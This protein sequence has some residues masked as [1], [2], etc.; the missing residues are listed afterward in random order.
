MSTEQPA[1]GSS[2]EDK[3]TAVA[4]H[5]SFGYSS[6]SSGT[7]EFDNVFLGIGVMGTPG[8]LLCSHCRGFRAK[9]P[10]YTSQ[11]TAT[12]FDYPFSPW[13]EGSAKGQGIPD[14]RTRKMPQVCHC[15]AGRSLNISH[16][17]RN[18]TIP[19]R[20]EA[21]ALVDSYFEK[22]YSLYP[23]LIRQVFM[24]T[25]AQLWQPQHG[26][27]GPPSSEIE[28]D[29]FYALLNSVFALGAQNADY[30]EPVRRTSM[31]ALFYSRA[32]NSLKVHFLEQG[33][34]EFVQCL[35]LSSQYLQSTH[36]WEMCWNLV[37]LAVRVAQG[38]GLHISP[39]QFMESYWAPS[40]ELE[41]AMRR[42]VWAGCVTMDRILALIYGKPQMLH[43]SVTSN[44]IYNL[45]DRSDEELY[46]G[47]LI[48]KGQSP[49]N[50]DFF[51]E[52]LHLIHYLGQILDLHSAREES[53]ATIHV[54]G[55]AFRDGN[56]SISSEQL[57][58]M[59][60]LDATMVSWN[61]RLPKHLQVSAGETYP[62]FVRQ[63]QMLNVRYLHMRVFLLRPAILALYNYSVGS[64]PSE[65]LESAEHH[66]KLSSLTQCAKT[67][68]E[69]N[70]AVIDAVYNDIIGVHTPLIP[71]WYGL[72]YVY[73]C[74]TVVHAGRLCAHLPGLEN[75]TELQQSFQKCM[76]CLQ[77][78]ETFGIAAKKCRA[79]LE[80][81]E[82]R[83]FPVQ[84]LTSLPAVAEHS[85]W[86][87]T[88]GHV[89]PQAPVYGPSFQPSIPTESPYAYE[90]SSTTT[91]SHFTP[92]ADNYFWTTFLPPG[93]NFSY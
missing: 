82:K 91:T 50:I 65:E 72:Y 23:F 84:P 90:G 67:C 49:R 16:A 10:E 34:I 60:N 2:F 6:T 71:W 87:T 59:V 28:T 51:L 42:R 14:Q 8:G 40:F 3:A 79:A 76:V 80:M 46:S 19:P 57:Q 66:V 11:S 55:E 63:S 33:N 89:S 25:Y 18:W 78:Y 41:E 54:P 35:L 61:R 64:Q 83:A 32:I 74:A 7:E 77:K 39:P 30:L 13:A 22:V 9:R 48:L 70:K 85:A 75:G 93:G 58:I 26:E 69:V 31:S 24:S 44:F 73:F 15:W 45:P 5:P 68:L 12:N 47:A 37:G 62:L 88:S 1:I 53:S 43:P 29:A 81:L 36:S 21:D 27:Y 17:V 92:D 38:I 86:S 52:S 56:S 20:A 4:E